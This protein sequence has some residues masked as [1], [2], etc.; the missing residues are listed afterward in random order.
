MK[1]IRYV[2]E[3]ISFLLV[4]FMVA[5]VVGFGMSMLFPPDNGMFMV[6]IGLD[7]RNLPG[8]ILGILAGVQSFRRSIREP[9]KKEKTSPGK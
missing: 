2:M 6:G 9:V 7:W 1:P 5:V 4:W 8:T 3:A